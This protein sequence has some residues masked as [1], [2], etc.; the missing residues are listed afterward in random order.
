M[1]PSH[2][3]LHY[4]GK[5]YSVCNSDRPFFNVVVALPRMLKAQWRSI[6]CLW[7]NGPR[8]WIFCDISHLSPMTQMSKCLSDVKFVGKSV[9]GNVRGVGRWHIARNNARP[10]Y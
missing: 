4:V 1:L 3:R 8:R 6:M 7:D 2:R 10:N 9:E 5:S